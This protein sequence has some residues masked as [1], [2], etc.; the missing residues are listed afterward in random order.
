MNH[1]DKGLSRLSR[2]GRADTYN[3]LAQ[4]GLYGAEGGL[5]VRADEIPSVSG[6][7]TT[8]DGQPL[9][10]IWAELQARLNL[11]NRQSSAV[12]SL[13]TFPVDRAQDRVA[14]WTTAKFEEATELGRPKKTRF[15]YVQRAFPLQHHDLGL[16]FT[17]EFIDSSKGSEIE[18]IRVQVEAAWTSLLLDGALMAL[19]SP[20][21]ATDEDSLSIKRLYNND[22]E[23]PPPWKRFTHLGSH[24]HYLTSG[25]ASFDAVDVAA[26]EDHLMHHGYGDNGETLILFMNRAEI[27][28]ARTLTGFVPAASASVPVII[29]GE[30]VGQTRGAP[31]GLNIQGYLGTFV[32]V[33]ENMIPAGYLLGMATGG[34]FAQQ[35]PVGYRRHENPSVRG[36]RLVE[37]NRTNYPI[38]DSVYD[39]YAG[40]G[41]RHR[42]A[43]VVMQLTAGAYAAPTL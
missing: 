22:G 30:V 26:M 41:V 23:V 8:L 29:N 37:G 10:E 38:I 35:N 25:A 1:T 20:T 9:S 32:I 17:Q 11:Y 12:F 18:S 28:V 39:G 42:G 36:L 21:N 7:A 13:F 14:V 2:F 34:R 3:K 5:V 19:F 43:A 15:K 6:T 40:F 24:Q 16:G 27:A 4:L 33:E 31:G